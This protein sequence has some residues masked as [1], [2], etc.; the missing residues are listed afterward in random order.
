MTAPD[1]PAD[2]RVFLGR[3]RELDDLTG[4]LGEAQLGR[5]RLYLLRGEAGI[6]KTAL[7][8]A[9]SSRAAAANCGVFWGR[10]WDGESTPPYWPWV[11]ILRACGRAD[12]VPALQAPPATATDFA[13]PLSE[14]SPHGGSEVRGDSEQARFRLFGAVT[15]TSENS[16]VY[17]ALYK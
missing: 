15:D 2:E 11:Q 5:G 13:H 8:E 9:I 10:S 6:G 3:E 14:L 17:S 4:A 12:S 7:A 1:A 16:N